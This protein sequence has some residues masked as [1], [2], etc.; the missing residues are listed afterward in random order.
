MEQPTNR[1]MLMLAAWSGPAM[2]VIF[3]LGWVVAA[4][5]IPPTAPADSAEQIRAFYMNN[6]TGI[7]IGMILCAIGAVL[8]VPFGAV[9]A[10]LLRR[11]EGGLPVLT[12][13]QLVCSAMSTVFIV[14]TATAY[15]VAAFRPDEAPAFVT[16]GFNDLGSFFAAVWTPFSLWYIAIALAIFRDKGHVPVYPRWVAYANIL[17][18]IGY[19]P[20]SL[21]ILFK[22][23]PFA[24]NG[25][26]S[27]YEVMVAFFVWI[28]VMFAYTIKAIN[29][30]AQ[31]RIDLHADQG[32]HADGLTLP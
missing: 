27:Y 12:Y 25:L 8:L 29:Q 13:T 6:L 3:L 18:A 26:I 11:T 4:H 9:V 14:L 22:T 32:S 23:G 7:R 31:P 28:V 20:A 19:A 24:M 17:L 21:V 1:K 16:V 10:V 2:A 5:F 30:L 15:G